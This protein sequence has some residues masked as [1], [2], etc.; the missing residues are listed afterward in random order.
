MTVTTGPPFGIPTAQTPAPQTPLKMEAA[1]V[2]NTAPCHHGDVSLIQCHAR[3]TNRPTT[4]SRKALGARLL[5]CPVP[6]FTVLAEHATC[7]PTPECT[8]DMQYFWY[9]AMCWSFVDLLEAQT[10]IVYARLCLTP[11]RLHSGS[12]SAVESVVLRSPLA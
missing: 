12:F 1:E 7:F 2:T 5:C 4:C 11:V 8:W 10:P 6:V 9:D 3:F